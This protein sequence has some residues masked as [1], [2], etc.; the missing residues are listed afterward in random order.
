[1]VLG[2]VDARRENV[3]SRSAFVTGRLSLESKLGALACRTSACSG[4]ALLPMC[5]FETGMR[6]H[7]P[8]DL[9]VRR[10][11]L[12]L[13][14]VCKFADSEQRPAVCSYCRDGP[15]SVLLASSPRG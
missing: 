2:G 10:T 7:G 12:C 9:I 11:A 14:F 6:P 3:S 8:L 1:M 13:M 4:L 5:L 15:M